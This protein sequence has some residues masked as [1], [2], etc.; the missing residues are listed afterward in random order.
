MA[1]HRCFTA[2]FTLCHGYF[3][4]SIIMSAN[5]KKTLVFC[6]SLFFLPGEAPPLFWDWVRKDWGVR[7]A[8]ILPQP[9]PYYKNICLIN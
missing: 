9:V 6:T 1:K 5:S 4:L 3:V 8:K 2:R 7:Q